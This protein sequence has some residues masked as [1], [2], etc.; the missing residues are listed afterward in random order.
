MRSI[1]T[2]HSSPHLLRISSAT[3]QVEFAGR[4]RLALRPNR[5]TMRR[6]NQDSRRRTAQAI[7]TPRLKSRQ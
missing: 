7:G 1:A 4:V 6:L 2:T 3:Q 5:K